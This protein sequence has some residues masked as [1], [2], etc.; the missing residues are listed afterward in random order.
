V[1]LQDQLGL[2]SI[3]PVDAAEYIHHLAQLTA[4][5]TGLVARCRSHPGGQLGIYVLLAGGGLTET[6]SPESVILA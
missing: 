5:G 1:L 4:R 6:E 2:A 3:R